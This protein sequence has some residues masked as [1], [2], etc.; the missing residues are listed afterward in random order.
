MKVYINKA[1][2]TL[3]ESEFS[4]HIELKSLNFISQEEFEKIIEASYLM[5]KKDILIVDSWELYKDY[6]ISGSEYRNKF[7]DGETPTTYRDYPN[8]P[9]KYYYINA[10]KWS[11][12]L[13]DEHDCFKVPK[14]DTVITN[15]SLFCSIHDQ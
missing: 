13:V 6:I 8:F 5:H 1:T 7:S 14:R 3:R 9:E 2:I 10:R 12:I 15:C 4:S 11:E